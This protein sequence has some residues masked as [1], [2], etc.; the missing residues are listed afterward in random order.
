M[1][2]TQVAAGW[3]GHAARWRGSSSARARLRSGRHRLVAHLLESGAGPRGRA[4]LTHMSAETPQPHPAGASETQLGPSSPAGAGPLRRPP[5]SRVLVVGAA[6]DGV[7]LVSF[8]GRGVWA[9]ASHLFA[10][11]LAAPGL[12]IETARL[13]LLGLL[14]AGIVTALRG[15]S[16]RCALLLGAALPLRLLFVLLGERIYLSF[17]FLGR[18]GF[19][20]PPRAE[21]HYGLTI[22]AV[23]LEVVRVVLVVIVGVKARRRARSTHT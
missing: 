3:A 23:L 5:P 21:Y 4:R 8:A 2:R 13:A 6:L 15:S 10:R 18:L 16:G 9:S 17:W 20:L 11:D 1:C 7:V 14:F 22:L 19:L 12:W